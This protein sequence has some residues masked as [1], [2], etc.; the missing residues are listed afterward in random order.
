MLFLKTVLDNF[1]VTCSSVARFFHVK[2]S[3]LER[4]YKKSL[5]D[6]EKWDQKGHAADWVLLA[7]NIGEYH[8][9]DE[10]TIG[11]DVYTILSNKDGHGRKGTLVA[12]VKGTKADAVSGILRKIPLS[13]REKVK[14]VT[15]DFSDSMYAIVRACFPN[16]TIVIDCFHIVQRLCE[17][18][19]EMRMRFKR[20][21]VTKTKKEEA[22]WKK[23]EEE[24]AKR[25][26]YARKWYE[27]KT[28]GKRKPK[29][30]K[31]GRKRL[32]R[33]KWRP[34]VLDNGDTLVELLTRARY[35][36][37][38]SGDKWGEHQK[39]RAGL[40]FKLYPK[41]KEAYS[42]ICV[43]RAIF[44]DKKLTR[45]QARERLRKWYDMV[46]ACTIREIKSARDCIKAKEEEVLNYFIN[47]HTN[48]P[49]ES[50][51]SKIKGF[52]AQ[53]HGVSDI[54]FFMYRMCKVFG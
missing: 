12:V 43:V 31:R 16:A 29:G 39:E 40:L 20:L 21:A 30:K 4:N 7:G 1:P 19:D 10:T 48:A 53:V 37:P 18:L 8:S 44:R 34:T 54:P 38:K 5:S 35:V 14:E 15:M 26:A 36:L 47:R 33:K 13:E 22:A 9:I 52:R 49:A 45:E 28:E 25:R 50:L 6:F 2:G 27:K 32:R 46:N 3:T 24:K 41:L 11:D 51:N 23:D 42:L 17:A